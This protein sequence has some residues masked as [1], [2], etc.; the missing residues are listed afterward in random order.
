MVGD[1]LLLSHSDLNFCKSEDET[2]FEEKILF[3]LFN[4]EFRFFYF[5]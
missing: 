5:K 3:H 2:S 4:C 1:D